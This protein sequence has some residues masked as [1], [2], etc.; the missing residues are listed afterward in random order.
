MNRDKTLVWLDSRDAVI[1]RWVDGSPQL[2]RLHS[3]VPAHR[4]SAGHVRR[5]PSIRPGGG[6]GAKSSGEPRRLEH[7]AR[8]LDSV[9]ERLPSDD[10]VLLGPGTVRERLRSRLRKG[11]SRHGLTRTIEAERRGP[12]TKRQL[13]AELRRLVGRAPRRRGLGRPMRDTA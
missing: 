9:V 11:D 8:F 1:A 7:L 4:R 12:R 10:L 3:N 2:E 6:G 5:D 13:I